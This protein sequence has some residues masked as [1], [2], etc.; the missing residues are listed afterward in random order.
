MQGDPLTGCTDLRVGLNGSHYRRSRNVKIAGSFEDLL[1]G[2]PDIAL[3]L[4]E[5]PES[6][7]MAINTSA[8]CQA[9]FVGNFRGTPPR[10]EVGFDLRSFG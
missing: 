3:A 1:Q 6:M 5:K 9:V 10:N 8:V 4:G 7:G 2:C